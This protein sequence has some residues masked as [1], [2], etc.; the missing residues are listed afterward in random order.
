LFGKFVTSIIIF[1]YGIARRCGVTDFFGLRASLEFIER[2][3]TA[4]ANQGEG[5][6]RSSQ[7]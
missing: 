1:L 6:Y 3:S 5:G 4:G 7:L 2:N